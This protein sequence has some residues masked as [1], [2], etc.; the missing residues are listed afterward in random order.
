MIKH[1]YILR[2]FL[3]LFQGVIFNIFFDKT[4]QTICSTS[5]DRSVRVWTKKNPVKKL[6]S[7]QDWE[8]ETYILTHTMFGHNARVWRCFVANNYIISI[9]EVGI[10]CH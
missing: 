7:I 10:H 8:N 3:F 6:I 2:F 9:G 5:D 1:L 4:T